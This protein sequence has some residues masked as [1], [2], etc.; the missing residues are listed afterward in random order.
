MKQEI[1]I[2]IHIHFFFSYFRLLF[3]DNEFSLIKLKMEDSSGREHVIIVRLGAGVSIYI[4]FSFLCII[5]LVLLFF[6]VTW[7]MPDYRIFWI[8]IQSY[9]ITYTYKAYKECQHIICYY[10]LVSFELGK[11]PNLRS[12]LCLVCNGS[13]YIVFLSVIKC[14]II[15]LS[16]CG[17]RI[18]GTHQ[19]VLVC[20]IGTHSI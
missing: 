8:I 9:K 20:T 1:F 6:G 2:W 11:S 12:V 13:H 18:R 10:Y 5:S 3:V 17:S 14:W 16:R 4:L 7:E 19:T 15:R